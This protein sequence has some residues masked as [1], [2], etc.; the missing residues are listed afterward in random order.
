MVK[1]GHASISENGTVNGNKGDQ[2]GKEVC[3]RD[4]YSKPWTYLLRPKK[5]SIATK[6]VE[7]CKALCSN[8]NIGYSQ[9][10]RNSLH[11]ELKKINYDYKKLNVPCNCDCS[12][13]ITV[14]LLCVGISGLEYSSN[15]PT[16]SIMVNA[17]LN[18]GEFDLYTDSKYLSSDKYLKK[19]DILV[20]PGSHT[21][22]VLEDGTDANY[23]S[24]SIDNKI[25]GIDIS[26]WQKDEIN[27]MQAK[28]AG[29][30]FVIIRIGYNQTKDPYF[31][32]NYKKAKEAGLLV[33]A[34]FYSTNLTETELIMDSNRVLN[35]LNGKKLEL[36]IACD[37]EESSMKLS[38]RKDINSKMYNAFA[39]NL[40]SNG[41]RTMLYTGE[42]MYNNCFNKDL[43]VDPLWIAKYSST[44]PNVGKTVSIWQYTSDAISNDFYKSKLDRNELLVSISELMKERNSTVYKI[45]TQTDFIK[46]VCNILCVT[47][48]QNAL[49]KTITISKKENQH[50]ALVTS[51]ERYMKELGYYIG[52]I[53]ADCGK[54]PEFGSGME[55]AIKIY[56]RDVVKASVQ[57]QDGIIDAKKSTWK[58]LLGLQ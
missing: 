5:E 17:F 15:A 35:W 11:T 31:E 6:S 42:W 2:T 36:P 56:Q 13:F 33:G 45:Y 53:E 43:I 52:S 40:K 51:L 14:I 54:T 37:L 7:I 8:E 46:D 39:A 9:A 19:G 58:K 23:S 4:W 44:K 27:F 12:S 21:I 47:T 18:T 25:K 48:A 26:K 24:T 57:Y 16:T 22:L 29:Y 49:E 32:S 20:K 1:I 38:S 55:K 10:D 34:Y 41:Y 30:S 50:H 28:S 3:I